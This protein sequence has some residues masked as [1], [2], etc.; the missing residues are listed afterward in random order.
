MAFFSN[1]C[2][3]QLHKNEKRWCLNCQKQLCQPWSL[4]KCFFINIASHQFA[5]LS[6]F[7]FNCTDQ[8]Q[9]PRTVG[10]L[11]RRAPQLIQGRGR[12]GCKGERKKG[13]QQDRKVHTV[14]LPLVLL[15]PLPP[16]L[17]LWG[18]TCSSTC[19]R[20]QLACARNPTK[21]QP[22]VKKIC[23]MHIVYWNSLIFQVK[24]R[25]LHHFLFT[26]PGSSQTFSCFSCLWLPALPLPTS[27]NYVARLP[28][29]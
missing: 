4:H 20:V 13:K 3:W 23:E 10:V 25:C 18:L 29:I 2:V 14:C 7:C 17:T 12:A 24:L 22:Y 28:L 19:T 1:C 26:I 6:P 9:I 21:V 5:S 27:Q 15:A 11:D 16:R 8:Y